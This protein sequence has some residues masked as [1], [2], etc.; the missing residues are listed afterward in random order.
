MSTPR[1]YTME[2]YFKL[3]Y[4]N[5][6][7]RI[8][9]SSNATIFDLFDEASI[10]FQQYINYD[11]YYIDYVV[12]GQDKSELGPAVI[13]NNLYQPL[14]YKFAD[15][16]KQ[17]SFYIRPMNKYT[18]RFICMETYIEELSDYSSDNGAL[19]VPELQLTDLENR[20]AHT[21]RSNT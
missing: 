7:Y 4:T 10:K 3:V 19:A 9:I 12:A 1:D 15:K 20:V 14:W 6:T 18:D 8:Q 2:F 5:I 11:K 17:I 16:W 21:L 13:M